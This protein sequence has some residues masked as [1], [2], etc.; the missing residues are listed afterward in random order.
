MR[1]LRW[2]SDRVAPG[3]W[4]GMSSV[5]YGLA[6]AQIATS[7]G[8]GISLQ[9]RTMRDWTALESIPV[10]RTTLGFEYVVMADIPMPWRDHFWASLESNHAR[11]VV[12]GVGPAALLQDWRLWLRT[13]ALPS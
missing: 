5:H 9:E 1:R 4:L 7:N 6:P 3:V 11:I 8:E 12:D 10:R 2:L 13:V